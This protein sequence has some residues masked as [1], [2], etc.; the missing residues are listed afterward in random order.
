MKDLK[1]CPAVCSP[2]YCDCKEGKCKVRS[3]IQN[4]ITMKP[5]VENWLSNV[6]YDPVGQYLW[7]T[8]QNG[9]RQMVADIRGFGALE[10][11]F[12]TPKD[13]YNFQ[14]KIGEFIAQAIQ[15]KIERL[16]NNKI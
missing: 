10:H 11:M 12:E 6:S 1:R 4:L 15:E 7:N 9:E 16:K 5:T 8:Q 13:V 3:D 14:D 2:L